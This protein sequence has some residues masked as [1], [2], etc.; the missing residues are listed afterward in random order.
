[1]NL[2]SKI[3]EFVKAPYYGPIKANN[4]L[5]AKLFL[6]LLFWQLVLA[7]TAG[8]VMGLFVTFFKLELGEHAIREMVAKNSFLKIFFLTAVIAPVLEELLFRAPLGLF[9]NK[10]FYTYWFYFFTIAFGLVHLMNFENMGTAIWFAP[11][12]VSP[13]LIAG[14]F[15]G[16]TRNKLGLLYSMALHALFNLILVSPILIFKL[17]KGV[18]S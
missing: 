14:I 2:L 9:R 13:Q 15:L 18:V 11:I 10:S 12:L 4:R 17:L 5:K 7:F 16:Y 8:M 6:S 3:W 1:M